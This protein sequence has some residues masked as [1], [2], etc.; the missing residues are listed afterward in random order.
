MTLNNLVNHSILA[1]SVI[2]QNNIEIALGLIAIFQNNIEI[3]S[4]LIALPPL[5]ILIA[6]LTS[7]VEH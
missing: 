1:L 3:A 7:T 5:T 4:G 6:C 2:F